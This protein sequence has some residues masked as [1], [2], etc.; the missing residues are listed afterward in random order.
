LDFEK[1]LRYSLAVANATSASHT[2]ARGSGFDQLSKENLM[3]SK[4]ALLYVAAVTATLV[5]M[6]A[7]QAAEEKKMKAD[8]NKDGMVS[9][10]EFMKH[11]GAMFD[12]MSEKKKMKADDY[13]TF[14]KQLMSD[15]G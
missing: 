11:A 10:E 9:K 8:E 6:P 1:R 5:A 4:K 2:K 7:A 13:S 3:Q 14:L 15:G 12:K